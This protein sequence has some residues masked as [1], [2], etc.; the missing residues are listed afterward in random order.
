MVSIG[1]G[2]EC[3][4]AR[5]EVSQAWQIRE[6]LPIVPG[7]DREVVLIMLHS[8]TA[9]CGIETE[10]Q[11]AFLQGDAIVTAEKRHQQLAFEQWVRRMPLNVEELAIGAVSPPFQ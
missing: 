3:P 7:A 11:G 4:E 8:K 6:N 5:G 9:A 2:V 1:A 10:G